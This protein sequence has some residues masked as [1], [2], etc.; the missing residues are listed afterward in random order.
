M[1]TNGAKDGLTSPLSSEYQ[2]KYL[3][4]LLNML[5][6][7]TKSCTQH[8]VFSSNIFLKEVREFLRN[9]VTIIDQAC[10]E[11]LWITHTCIYKKA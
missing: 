10:L 8:G 2:Q 3:Q 7:L 4:L 9:A 1:V 6:Q 11:L 5:L